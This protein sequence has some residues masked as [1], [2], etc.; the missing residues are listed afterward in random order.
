MYTAIQFIFPD[1]S[2]AYNYRC[3]E[4]VDRIEQLLNYVVDRVA[5][6]NLAYSSLGHQVLLHILHNIHCTVFHI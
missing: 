6:G 5:T 2:H 4:K 3:S 1:E